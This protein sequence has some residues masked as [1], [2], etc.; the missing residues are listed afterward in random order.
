[1]VFAPASSGIFNRSTNVAS[2]IAYAYEV[3][4]FQVS[5]G[6]DWVRT[7]RYDVTARAGHE[8]TPAELRDMVKA[9]LAERFNLR[10]R[11]C[12]WDAV[13]GTWGPT[14]TTAPTST[15]RKAYRHSTSR[16]VRLATAPWPPPTARRASGAW[17]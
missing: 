9:M 14:C 17:P 6:E 16:F 15:T 13:M 7:E 2:L 4:D 11:S 1:V 8:V 3:Q 10:V 12:G 5:G